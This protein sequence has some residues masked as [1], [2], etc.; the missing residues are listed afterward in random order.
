H[1]VES[2][3]EVVAASDEDASV[4]EPGDDAAGQ[5]AVDLVLG[6]TGEVGEE[7]LQRVGAGDERVERRDALSACKSGG[8]VT[9]SNPS[10]VF[11][12]PGRNIDRSDARE[13]PRLLHNPPLRSRRQGRWSERCRRPGQATR[14]C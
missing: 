8:H 3:G 12:V 2:F 6:E 9:R 10:T 11:V 5:L 13:L 4:L 1:L 7:V 14:A